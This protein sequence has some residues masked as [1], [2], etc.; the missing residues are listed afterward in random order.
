MS[1]LINTAA[2]ICLFAMLGSPCL[3]QSSDEAAYRKAY[4]AAERLQKEAL[5]YQNGWTVTTAA[6]KSA[7]DAADK[8]DFAAAAKLAEHAEAFAQASVDQSKSQKSLWQ[9][10]IVK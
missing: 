2:S 8:K 6:L 7:K 1:K 9:E 10:A 4:E 3:A 5:S